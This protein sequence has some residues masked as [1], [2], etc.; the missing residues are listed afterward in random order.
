ML[1]KCIDI[2]ENLEPFRGNLRISLK[3]SSR[4]EFLIYDK[5]K[6]EKATTLKRLDKFTYVKINT[7]LIYNKRYYEQVK[8]ISNIVAEEICKHVTCED[9]YLE[10][11]QDSKN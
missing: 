7:K 4:K 1:I 11:K 9:L 6:H 2:K 10:Y 8:K 3:P 5:Q